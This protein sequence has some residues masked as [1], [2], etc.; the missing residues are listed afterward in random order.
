MEEIEAKFLNINP[1]DIENRLREIGADKFGEIFYRRRVFDYPD[2]RLSKAGAWVRIRTDGQH[3]TLTFKQ[4]LGI[5]AHDG[6]ANDETMKKI[7]II[8][9]DF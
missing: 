1:V 7:E 2:L 6:S 4:R 3:S 5:K 8:M 9:E